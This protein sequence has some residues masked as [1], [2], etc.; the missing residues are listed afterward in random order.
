[1]A[2]LDNV[3]AELVADV[4]RLQAGTDVAHHDV[5]TALGLDGAD[6]VHH[7]VLG[8]LVGVH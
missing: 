5:D 7:L 4:D 6:R 1:M 3:H 2:E 8:R